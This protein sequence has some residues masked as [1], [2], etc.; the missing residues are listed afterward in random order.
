MSNLQSFGSNWQWRRV[1]CALPG[2]S[3]LIRMT[4]PKVFDMGNASCLSRLYL[5][6]CLLLWSL[7]IA[8]IRSA[9]TSLTDLILLLCLWYFL[10]TFGGRCFLSEDSL[11]TKLEG[12]V[13]HSRNALI[14]QTQSFYLV[15]N[16]QVHFCPWII[17]I[18]CAHPGL[19]SDPSQLWPNSNHQE[20]NRGTCSW[21]HPNA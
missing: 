15:R 8:S 7:G 21:F 12:A 11:Y 20:H 2:L 14:P 9:W 17:N 18:L 10:D 4:C 3:F 19:L 6:L 5:L 1:D 16:F 13:S